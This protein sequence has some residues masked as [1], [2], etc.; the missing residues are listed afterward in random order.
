MK[1][2]SLSDR[3]ILAAIALGYHADTQGTIYSPAGE[4]LSNRSAKK[5]GRGGPTDG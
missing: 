1:Q 4:P 5:A 3:F 2:A